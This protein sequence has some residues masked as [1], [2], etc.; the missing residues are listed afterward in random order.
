M[1][2]AAVP[3][4]KQTHTHFA[5]AADWK[6]VSVFID[7][8]LPRPFQNMRH[9]MVSTGLSKMHARDTLQ[10]RLRGPKLVQLLR[11][12]VRAMKHDG[13]LLN[14]ANPKLMPQNLPESDSR[15]GGA[16]ECRAA[17]RTSVMSNAARATSRCRLPRWSV[18]PATKEESGCH[19]WPLLRMSPL[20]RNKDEWYLH[21]RRWFVRREIRH[22]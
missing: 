9:P 22:S 8:P 5:N 21:P 6:T 4:S 15:T 10:L 16:R 17:V 1:I 13:R 18:N 20:L 12:S 7:G 3:T 11:L 19:Q 2:A 14:W